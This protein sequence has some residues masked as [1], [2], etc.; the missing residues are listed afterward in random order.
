MDV[1]IA[2]FQMRSVI[3]TYRQHVARHP[4]DGGAAAAFRERA[5]PLLD[6]VELACG[7][8][9]GIAQLLAEAR[10]ELDGGAH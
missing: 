2:K 3:V 1:T 10:R 9:P 5:R 4:G 7:T 8:K 6:S